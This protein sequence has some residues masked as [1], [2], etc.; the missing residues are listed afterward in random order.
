VAVSSIAYLAV[1]SSIATKVKMSSTLLSEG[2]EARNKEANRG[3]T[4][5]MDG[6]QTPIPF[7][8]CGFT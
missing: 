6:K 2:Y 5:V 3:S 1:F 8:P 4:L 7:D